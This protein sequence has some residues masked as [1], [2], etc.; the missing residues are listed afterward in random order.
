MHTTIQAVKGRKKT[1]LFAD[2]I[3]RTTGMINMYFVQNV[4]S[5]IY[6]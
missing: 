4:D 2:F 3:F 1:I 5:C 6:I